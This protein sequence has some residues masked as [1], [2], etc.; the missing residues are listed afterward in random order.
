MK[1]KNT[2]SIQFDKI[3][4]LREK[5]SLDSLFLCKY[6]SIL[7]L[8]YNKSKDFN[9]DSYNASFLP[10][11][12]KDIK[13][14]IRLVN[15]DKEIIIKKENLK[16]G[17]PYYGD[18][19]CS[20]I[21]IWLNGYFWY[22]QSDC[23]M[24]SYEK[25]NY[26]GEAPETCTGDCFTPLISLTTKNKTDYFISYFD[27]DSYDDSLDIPESI[28]LEATFIKE[29]LGVSSIL[30][31][32][33]GLEEKCACCGKN[34]EGYMLTK[35]LWFKSCKKLK[36]NPDRLIC[37]TCIHKSLNRRLK[38]SDFIECPLN[39]GVFGFDLDIFLKHQDY[40]FVMNGCKINN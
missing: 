23:G 35:E 3:F 6:N 5:E 34:N 29:K 4:K 15:K 21:A 1:Y 11:K 36:I 19:R 28:K 40:I 2:I 10:T 24:I 7:E 39:S 32:N 22:V 25:T 9:F 8:I 20:K 13:E 12:N 31:N 26:I 33:Y 27:E 30:Q 18:H 37:I 14:F 16:N 17:H 38:K